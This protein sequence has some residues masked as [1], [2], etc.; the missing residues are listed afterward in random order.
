MVKH[1]SIEIWLHAVLQREKINMDF[2][3]IFLFI[4]HC[5]KW[6]LFLLPGT[7]GTP[8]SVTG[9][10]TNSYARG[11]STTTTT[12]TYQVGDHKTQG[13]H[14]FWLLMLM[15]VFYSI[16]SSWSDIYRN[17][18]AY[19]FFGFSFLSYV[20]NHQFISFDVHCMLHFI[21]YM[22]LKGT[23]IIYV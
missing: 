23:N 20:T 14:K 22:Y 6:S 11:R 18:F 2:I 13:K 9:R 8:P 16:D 17:S 12:S 10:Q 7:G 15:C 5:M 4:E 3:V 19:I 1:D 21:L